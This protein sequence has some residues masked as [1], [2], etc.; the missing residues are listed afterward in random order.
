MICHFPGKH[1]RFRARIRCTVQVMRERKGVS[2]TVKSWKSGKPILCVSLA[3]GLLMYAVPRLA[4]GGGFSVEN[5]FGIA[6][7]CFALLIVAAHLHE[8]LGV[9]EEM[10]RELCKVKRMKRWQRER[11]L[12]G[13]T[14][15]RT[16]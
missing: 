11:R 9:D 10:R 7:L 16:H 15:V 2:E 13:Q 5:F 6:W 8:V 1:I 3:L 12:L 4:I 14:R